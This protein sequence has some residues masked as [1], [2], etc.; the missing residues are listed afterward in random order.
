LAFEIRCPPVA[1]E[2]FSVFE[3]DLETGELR[4]I[5]RRVHLTAQAAKVLTLLASRPGEV[6][7]REELKRHLWGAETFVDFDRSLNFCVSAARAALRD[8]ARNPQFIETLPRR[9]YRFMAEAVV[10]DPIAP[11]A[12]P[13]RP[14]LR[15]GA[16][17]GVRWLLAAAAMLLLAMQQPLLPIAH[18]R[19]TARPDARAA[20]TRAFD[21]PSGDAAALRRS[22]AD[23]KLATQL[24]PRFA[25]AHYALADLYLK[26]AIRHELP[27]A[28]ALAE[29]EA[30]ARRAI[31]LEDVPETRQVLGTVRLLAAWDWTG[32]RREL[33]RAIALAPTWDI[34]HA[35]YARVL[36]AVG[37]DAAA[38][39]AI[40]R[41]ETLSPTCELILADA[42][43]IYARA[44]RFAEAVGKLRR[45][46]DL[47][48][49][50]SMT[51]E[52]WR[53]DVQFRLLR[54]AVARGDWKAA[55][56]AAIA[57]LVSNGAAASVRRRFESDEPRDAVLRFLRR[58]VEKM[59]ASARDTHISPTRVGTL[60]ALLDDRDAAVDWLETAAA[61]RDPDL[62]YA[63]RDPDF[64]RLRDSP[65][66]VA[67]ERR[68]HVDRAASSGPA[69]VG[70]N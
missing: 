21:A 9:G 5:G 31:A 62:V 13:S 45:A 12:E 52:Q 18:T 70:P 4:R 53:A 8:S 42:G 59:Q 29:S 20:F 48:P 54:I 63:L 43:A 6:V 49:P 34:G 22:V 30:A 24:D 14:S 10:L 41:A 32:A 3:L 1:L 7:T 2:R 46:V 15:S 11:R 66:F 56:E 25:E 44:G 58:S 28:S 55:H 27:M 64:D 65:R 61:E 23:L 36:S 51:A 35:E 57:I 16:T 19:V 67:L 68:L 40:D 47:G 17:R 50:G 69:I 33:A 39:V 60:L 26:L 37:D 38:I